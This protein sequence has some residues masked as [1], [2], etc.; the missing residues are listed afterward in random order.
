MYQHPRC[1]NDFHRSVFQGYIL[2]NAIKYMAFWQ[3]FIIYY[4]LT[5]FTIWLN[6]PKSGISY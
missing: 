1:K 2:R 4:N 6:C 5:S 3:Y